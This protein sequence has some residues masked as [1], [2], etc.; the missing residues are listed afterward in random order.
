MK[1]YTIIIAV[2]SFTFFLFLTACD[3]NKEINESDPEKEKMDNFLESLFLNRISMGS[4]AALAN[5]KVWYSNAFGMADMEKG[6]DATTETKYRVGSITKTF[7]AVLIL[8]AVDEKRLSLNETLASY[9]PSV[10]NAELITISDL[11]YHRTGI[12]NIT[13]DEGYSEWYMHPKTKEEMID[14]IASYESDFLPDS[15]CEYSNSNYILLTFIL[16]K[17]YNNKY[18]V[19]LMEKITRPNGLTSTYVGGKIDNNN[20]EASSY[21][22]GDNWIKEVETDMS[23]PLGAGNIVSTPGDI[24]RFIKNLFDGKLIS[25][26]S[27]EQMTTVRDNM[28]M[29][30]GP[31]ELEETTG[32]GF[33]GG[34]DGFISVYIYIPEI[35]C[36]VTCCFNAVSDDSLENFFEILKMLTDKK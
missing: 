2:L 22:P 8:M 23:I 16:E 19:L 34:I 7:T 24:N 9:F 17:I 6:I 33:V 27:F 36:A 29:G 32:W 30:I 15:K 25:A 11:L 14:L 3:S 18:D 5:N 10:N 12:P 13:N 20:K 31:M 21:T 35:D 4:I 28:G 1:Q 26:K